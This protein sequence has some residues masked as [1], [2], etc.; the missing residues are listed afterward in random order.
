[1]L[2]PPSCRAIHFT[3]K[4]DDSRRPFLF[5]NNYFHTGSDKKKNKLLLLSLLDLPSDLVVY[6]TGDFNF[7]TDDDDT[8]GCSAKASRPSAKVLALR[9]R[10]MDHFHLVEAF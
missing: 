10:V 4:A 8:T 3:S 7:V 2:S 6:F 1:M 9:K 5:V